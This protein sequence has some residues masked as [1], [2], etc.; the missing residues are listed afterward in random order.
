MY[1]LAIIAGVSCPLAAFAES[2]AI[3]SGSVSVAWDGTAGTIELRGTGTH[4]VA[5]EVQSAPLSLQTG[6]QANLSTTIV[7]ST[8]NRSFSATVS[9]TTYPTVWVKG[10]LTF[11]ATPFAVPSE[12]VGSEH[13][14]STP[15]TLAG[16]FF[17]YS[18]QAMTKQ[19]FALSLSGSGVSTIGPMRAVSPDTYIMRSGGVTYRLTSAAPPPISSADVGAG[20]K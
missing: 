17:G 4:L 5:E 2:T 15:T 16:Q 13:F 19:V 14:F 11:T 7:T 9:G 18:D 6:Q 3:T 12:P 8:A 10:T 1:F 20:T